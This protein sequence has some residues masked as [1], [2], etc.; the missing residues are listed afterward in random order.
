MQQAGYTSYLLEAHLYHTVV[1]LFSD[2]PR[3]YQPVLK[4]IYID[5]GEIMFPPNEKYEIFCQ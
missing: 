5:S 4:G 1:T 3:I 2:E